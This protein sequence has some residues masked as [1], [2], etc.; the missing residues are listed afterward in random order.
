MG[1]YELCR[2]DLSEMQTLKGSKVIYSSLNTLSNGFRCLNNS[3]DIQQCV[4][5]QSEAQEKVRRTFLQ[6]KESN[7]QNAVKTIEY[8][9]PLNMRRFTNLELRD[10]L[11]DY[12]IPYHDEPKMLACVKD[13]W[14]V[15]FPANTA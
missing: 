3:N 7:A 15:I 9:S 1:R 5:Q 11:N 2:A 14:P 13:Y 4:N 6:Y 10:M 12:G 8:C